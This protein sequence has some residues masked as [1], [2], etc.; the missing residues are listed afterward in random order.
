MNTSAKAPAKHVKDAKAP[1]KHVKDLC[2]PFFAF[3]RPGVRL[4]APRIGPP[5]DCK[6]LYFSKKAAVF[7][8]LYSPK[9]QQQKW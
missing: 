5:M 4:P 8:Y 1:A 3:S 9:H 2:A 6:P 7:I